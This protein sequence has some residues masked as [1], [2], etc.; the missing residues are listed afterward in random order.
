MD[1]NQRLKKLEAENAQLKADLRDALDQIAKLKK[2]SSNSSKPPSSDI[3]AG[4]PKKEFKDRKKK[5]KRGGQKGRKA[6]V[7]KPFE[8]DRIDEVITHTDD[9][10]PGVWELLPEN[11][12]CLQQVELVECPLSITEHRFSRFRNRV[13]GRIYTTPRPNDLKG[14]GLFGPRMLALT[15]CLKSGLH[16]SYSAIQT[17]YRDAFNLPVSLGYLVKATDQ[18]TKSLAM[19][20]DALKQTVRR[21]SV[22]NIDETGHK[23]N[24]KRLMTW[25]ATCAQATVFRIADSRSTAELYALLGEDFEGVIGS[26]FFSAYLKYKREN[27]GVQSQYCWAHLI[28]E[29]LFLE[30]LTDKTIRTWAAKV[31]EPVKKLF[32]AWRRGQYAACRAAQ[33]Q[34]EKLCQRLPKRAEIKTLG[35]RMWKHR[36]AYFRFLEDPGLGIEPTNNSAERALRPVVMHR[37]VTQGTRSEKGRR[38][39]ECVWSV[40][41]TCRK[42][43]RSVFDY[44]VEVLKAHAVGLDPPLP[45]R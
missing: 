37:R 12:G 39:W 36:R 9:M 5:R 26:D 19:P 28:R 27:D 8:D 1:I 25:V 45:V 10:D 4:K 31:L 38:W 6:C 18:M 32:R 43:G 21:Q 2:N 7:R 41:M 13:A 34:I 40:T 3:I 35:G 11:Y 29:L 42:H 20:Y 17:L 33:G 23:E 24:G 16:G 30:G 15:T 44:L 14:Q 22:V